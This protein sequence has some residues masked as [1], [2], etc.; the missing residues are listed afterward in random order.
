MVNLS[1]IY[2]NESYPT[3]VRNEGGGGQGHFW[4]MS[5][6]KQLFFRDGF[7]KI[8]TRIRNE[9]N[10]N[11]RPHEMKVRGVLTRN[12]FFTFNRNK[13]YLQQSCLT[14]DASPIKLV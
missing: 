6:I 10:V 3:G 13:K 11:G 5:K 4:T 1:E 7:P 12:K 2:L 9:I 14:I 8:S